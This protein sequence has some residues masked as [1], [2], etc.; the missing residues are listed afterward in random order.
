MVRLSVDNAAV[1][2]SSPHLT[3]TIA[4]DAPAAIHQS[5]SSSS[6]SAAAAG[7][8]SA[9]GSAGGTHGGVARPA[10]LTCSFMDDW[11]L[12]ATPVI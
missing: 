7:L 10:A 5:S 6:T 3:D 2:T 12:K 1:M 4:A 9:A 11:K 8:G